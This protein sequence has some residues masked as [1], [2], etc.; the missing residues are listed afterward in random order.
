MHEVGLNKG[1]LGH[2]QKRVDCGSGQIRLAFSSDEVPTAS[3][4]NQGKGTC[5]SRADKGLWVKLIA[6]NLKEFIINEVLTK[7]NF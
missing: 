1:R 7:Y 2:N 3:V 6:M 4:A 5:G